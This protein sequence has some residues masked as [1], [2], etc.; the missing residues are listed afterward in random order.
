MATAATGG[1]GT[2][3]LGTDVAVNVK[4]KCTQTMGNSEVC[5]KQLSTRP[6][7]KADKARYCV[8]ADDAKQGKQ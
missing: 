1:F 8:T 6:I 2:A 5:S 4:Y 3:W 7:P